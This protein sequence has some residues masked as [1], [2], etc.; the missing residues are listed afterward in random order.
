MK[1]SKMSI[2]QR[3]VIDEKGRPPIPTHQ[4]NGTWSSG[5][6]SNIMNF[7][8]S[9]VIKRYKTGNQNITRSLNSSIEKSRDKMA[10]KF[11]FE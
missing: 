4:N 11:N 10:K 1:F 6:S 9:P 3:N 8:S 5:S 7:N 2:N